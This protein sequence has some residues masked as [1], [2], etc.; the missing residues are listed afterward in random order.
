MTFGCWSIDVSLFNWMKSNVESGKDLLELGSGNSTN[1]LCKLWNVYSIEENIDWVNR[2][3]SRYIYA[4]I[5][6]NWY[7]LDIVKNNIPKNIDI[8]LIDGP[9]HGD[10][11]GFFDNISM[12]LD[13]N[14]GIL[15]FDDVDRVSDYNCYINV[16]NHLKDRNI[17]IETGIIS[18]N[19]KFAFIKIM[20]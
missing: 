20:K 3:H 8:I 4:P 18:E 7:D 1:E 5:K 6:E 16:V 11:N 2:F 15:V 12:F 13:L 10:R 19:K 14:P 9:A 17:N